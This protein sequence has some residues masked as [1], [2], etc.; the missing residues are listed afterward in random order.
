ML[1]KLEYSKLSEVRR[2]N[3]K[4]NNAALFVE[5]LFGRPLRND[6]MILNSRMSYLLPYCSQRGDF[7]GPGYNESTNVH[8][9]V[10]SE[11]IHNENPAKTGIIG[12]LTLAFNLKRR[13]YLEGRAV[14][15]SH[16]YRQKI[17]RFNQEFIILTIGGYGMV[18]SLTSY[19]PNL[20]SPMLSGYLLFT[21]I[22]YW[23]FHNSLC[24]LTKKLGSPEKAFELTM[25]KPPTFFGL[26]FPSSF[27]RE[28]IERG[29]Q[30][31][32]NT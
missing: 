23:S 8:E 19:L 9:L 30:V 11:D 28:D 6:P 24:I 32:S 22:L 18:A 20:L 12:Y 5:G 25:E 31:Q 17:R 7:L 29:L 14:F 15:A 13:M 21:G 2:N 1:F 16:I 10:H 4:L 26:F 27:Y 3:S